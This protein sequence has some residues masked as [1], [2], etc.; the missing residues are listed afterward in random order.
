MGQSHEIVGHKVF[1]KSASIT[2]GIRLHSK[3]GLDFARF[4]KSIISNC[5]SLSQLSSENYPSLIGFTFFEN[6]QNIFLLNISYW[7]IFFKFSFILHSGRGQGGRNHSLC[8]NGKT[9]LQ[10]CSLFSPRHS[11]CTFSFIIEKGQSPEIVRH[12]FSKNHASPTSGPF[13]DILLWKMFLANKLFCVSF[14]GFW[15][16]YMLGLYFHHRTQAP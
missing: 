9:L 16:F 10:T 11:Y 15:L 5:R 13:F 14:H 6:K 8:D 7:W 3:L 12:K 4:V 2:T 1:G